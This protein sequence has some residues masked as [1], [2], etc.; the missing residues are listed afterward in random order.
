MVVQVLSTCI[1]IQI[2]Q[3]LFLYITFCICFHFFY[4]IYT[5]YSFFLFTKYFSFTLLF[6][7]LHFIYDFIHIS[8][9]L[10]TSIFFI[11]TYRLYYTWVSAFNRRHLAQYRRF[12]ILYNDSFHFLFPYPQPFK[13]DIC[14][15]LAYTDITYN[16]SC[17]KVLDDIIHHRYYRF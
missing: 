7:F 13:A 15:S 12:L 5:I 16:K 2:L 6:T 4:F 3:F 9:L 8:F 14:C 1:L 10:F 11:K 17:I